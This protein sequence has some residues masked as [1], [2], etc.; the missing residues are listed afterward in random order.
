LGRWTGPLKQLLLVLGPISCQRF[1]HSH[2]VFKK[3]FEF[4]SSTLLPIRLAHIGVVR[5]CPALPCP[6]LPCPA[7][8]DLA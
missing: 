7:L 6:A 8:L 1:W 3:F 4:F 2:K 5:P